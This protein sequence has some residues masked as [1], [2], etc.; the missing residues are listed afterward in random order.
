M[1]K[2]ISL[3]FMGI[4][5][6]LG[7]VEAFL[8]IKDFKYLTPL[9]SNL[10]IKYHPTIGYVPRPAFHTGFE[11]SL[12]SLN[13]EKFTKTTV[14]ETYAQGHLGVRLNE[15]APPIGENKVQVPPLP[16][17]G[18]IVSG[19]SFTFGVGVSNRDSWPAKLERLIEHPVVNAGAGGYGWDQALL[20]LEEVS[21][22]VTPTAFVLACIP[23]CLSRV[24]FS[25]NSG[26]EKSFFKIENGELRLMNVPVPGPKGPSSGFVSKIASALETLRLVQVY[27]FIT[28]LATDKVSGVGYRSHYGYEEAHRVTCKIFERLKGLADEHQV[29]AFVLFQYSIA[30]SIAPEFEEHP[31][32]DPSRR[33][34]M[35]RLAECAKASGLKVIDSY[36]GLS[37]KQTTFYEP[38]YWEQWLYEAEANGHPHGHHSAKGNQ[39]VAEAVA[40]AFATEAFFEELD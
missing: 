1:I 28:F 11:S 32:M 14:I 21:K 8:Q 4:F 23:E 7:L 22:V 24:F 27:N 25:Q 2:K 10:A 38:E 40:Q 39:V 35:L 20:R 30:Q 26:M 19:D 17:R 9:Q 6:A 15:N 18:I 29:S 5:V 33:I 31:F 13:D 37:E 3:L 16:K 34:H 12:L 36:F